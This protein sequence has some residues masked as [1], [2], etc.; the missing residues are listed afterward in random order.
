MLNMLV[1]I[2]EDYSGLK[3]R[4]SPAEMS[5]NSKTTYL[6]FISSFRHKTFINVSDNAK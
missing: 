5:P 4:L 2:Q 3:I 6:P 1:N